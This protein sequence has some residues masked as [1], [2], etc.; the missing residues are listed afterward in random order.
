MSAGALLSPV[1]RA[2]SPK[3]GQG[4]QARLGAPAGVSGRETNENEEVEPARWGQR[5]G[6]REQAP[7]SPPDTCHFPPGPEGCALA[8]GCRDQPH[9][10]SQVRP[11]LCTTVWPMRMDTNWAPEYDA[12]ID[13]TA[14]VGGRGLLSAALAQAPFATR[15]R[16]TRERV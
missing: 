9:Q 2:E 5:K 3:V 1:S 16:G 11:T 14:E 10:F 8:S 13:F 12:R 15:Q 7:P 6:L 4:S